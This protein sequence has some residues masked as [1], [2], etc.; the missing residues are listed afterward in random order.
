[1]CSS[2]EIKPQVLS[3]TILKAKKP[4]EFSLAFFSLKK[5]MLTTTEQLPA[6]QSTRFN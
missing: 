4:D 6:P 2:E 5:T 1:M 3:I